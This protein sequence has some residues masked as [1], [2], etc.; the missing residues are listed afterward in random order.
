MPAWR[1]PAR[2]DIWARCA[3]ALLTASERAE[4]LRLDAP[5]LDYEGLVAVL[6]RLIDPLEAFEEAER[7]V[8]A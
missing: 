8:P 5:V 3:A 7:S 6:G 4:R 1:D 2:E